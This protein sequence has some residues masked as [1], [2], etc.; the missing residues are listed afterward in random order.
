MV[1]I[2][3]L[4]QRDR[5]VR[6]SNSGVK[7]LRVTEVINDELSAQETNTHSM[8]YQRRNA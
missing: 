1:P 3:G 4:D 2:T 6:K 5:R 7:I 8:V